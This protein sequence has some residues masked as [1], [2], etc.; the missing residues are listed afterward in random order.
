MLVC[1]NLSL[2][3]AKELDIRNRERKAAGKNVPHDVFSTHCYRQPA[4][5]EKPVYPEPYRIDGSFDYLKNGYNG[6]EA[7][8]SERRG[9][10]SLNVHEVVEEGEDSEVVLQA[11]FNQFVLPLSKETNDHTDDDSKYDEENISRIQNERWRK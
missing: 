6:T 5:T 11:Y 8:S 3:F 1:Q 9:S 4:L 10:L 7:P 2:V